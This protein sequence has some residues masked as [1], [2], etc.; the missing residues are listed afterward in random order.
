MQGLQYN[1]KPEHSRSLKL[2]RK[3]LFRTVV[4][5]IFLFGLT[6]KGEVMGWLNNEIIPKVQNTVFKKIG[7]DVETANINPVDSAA[8]SIIEAQLNIIAR[9][10]E[11]YRV[12]DGTYP[13]NL[14]EFL[15]E[16]FDSEVKKKDVT[17]DSWGNRYY[18]S[19]NGETYELRSLGPDGIFGTADD[20]ICK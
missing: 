3:S 1:P 17:V 7:I 18:Y 13:K 19:A 12:A 11:Y 14:E 4:I 2:I 8:S 15:K 10:L 6:R 5:G 20:I 16:N 9:Q